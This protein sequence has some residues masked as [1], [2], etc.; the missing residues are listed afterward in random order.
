MVLKLNKTV[1]KGMEH[2][3]GWVSAIKMSRL[4]TGQFTYVRF[5]EDRSEYI[6][7]AVY[8]DDLMIEPS[9]KKVITTFQQQITAKYDCK[10]LGA[11]DRILNM[12][13]VHTK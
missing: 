12:E 9:S 2:G 4:K 7:L 8:V 3:V 11:L 1:S 10:D 13:V 6:V 5:N